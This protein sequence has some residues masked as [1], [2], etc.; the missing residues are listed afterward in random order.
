MTQT[1]TFTEIAPDIFVTTF[2]VYDAWN[3]EL[4]AG[5]HIIF[6]SWN[7][8]K[9]RAN[10]LNQAKRKWREIKQAGRKQFGEEVSDE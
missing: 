10:A 1:Y 4:W 2:Y 6:A 9:T 8:C 3:Y 5:G 7:G